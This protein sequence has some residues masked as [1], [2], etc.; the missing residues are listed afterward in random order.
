MIYWNLEE[1]R[2]MD[3]DICMVQSDEQVE[4]LARAW[5]LVGSRAPGRLHRMSFQETHRRDIHRPSR[6]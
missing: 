6:V 2:M 1:M 4:I 5:M 3:W